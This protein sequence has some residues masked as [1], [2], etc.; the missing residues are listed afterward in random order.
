M[1]ALVCSFFS[2]KASFY[3]YEYEYEEGI[4][5]DVSKGKREGV[6]YSLQPLP[7]TF[8]WLIFRPACAVARGVNCQAKTPTACHAIKRDNLTVFQLSVTVTMT[9]T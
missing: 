5:C 2:L 8:I 1:S 7:T 4:F 6:C 9:D 3:T